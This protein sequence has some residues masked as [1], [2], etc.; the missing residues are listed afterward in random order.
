MNTCDFQ[1][2]LGYHKL[3]LKIEPVK[4]S[5]SHITYAQRTAVMPHP[6]DAKRQH[7]I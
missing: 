1:A 2:I 7:N 6:N 3:V 5:T 4:L